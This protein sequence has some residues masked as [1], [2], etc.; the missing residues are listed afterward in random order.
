M[1]YKNKNGFEFNIFDKFI[2]LFYFF[3]KKVVF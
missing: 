3:I 2:Y 1:K